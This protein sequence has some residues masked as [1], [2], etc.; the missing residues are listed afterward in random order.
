MLCGKVQLEDFVTNIECSSG[1][2][3]WA[4]WMEIAGRLQIAQHVAANRDAEHMFPL[5]PAPDGGGAHSSKPVASRPSQ[6]TESPRW[7][8]DLPPQQARRDDATLQRDRLLAQ[9][10]MR[11]RLLSTRST[12]TQ[13]ADFSAISFLDETLAEGAA[14]GA[15]IVPISQGPKHSGSTPRTP[16]SRQSTDRGMLVPTTPK[17]PRT[18]RSSR[19]LSTPG[20]GQ[21]SLNWPGPPLQQQLPPPPPDESERGRELRMSAMHLLFQ[22]VGQSRAAL[23]DGLVHRMPP[24]ADMEVC[25]L[26]FLDG[27]PPELVQVWSPSPTHEALVPINL[28]VVEPL[29]PSIRRPRRPY[30]RSSRHASGDARGPTQARS[31]C[32]SP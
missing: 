8:E 21:D 16:A 19:Q 31:L 18:P 23:S 11:K 12:Q 14:V 17:T 13:P 29:T 24:V 3:R 5:S 30:V 1:V 9:T 15:R 27:R 25:R 6:Q 22:F 7:Q 28:T 10:I 32:P 2:E 20:H 4:L 26:L